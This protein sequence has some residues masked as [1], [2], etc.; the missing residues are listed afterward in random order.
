MKP[1]MRRLSI[2]AGIAVV[3]GSGAAWAASATEIRT[4]IKEV[5]RPARI[6]LQSTEKRGAVARPGTVLTLLA[7]SVPAKMLRVSRP[8]PT[9]PKI[10]APPRVRH[11]DSY[12]RVT[13][14]GDG[15]LTGAP[16]EL[17]LASGTR[18][19]LFD[20]RVEQGQVRFFTHTAEPVT[21]HD[22]GLAYGCTE[23]VFPVAAG[24]SV[25]EALGSINRVLTVQAG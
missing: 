14:A 25:G 18:L 1:L 9:H 3:L 8:E 23:F 19:V 21:G 2:V 4:A 5:Y 24:A 7:D 11:I 20:V 10:Q 17:T 13:V 22:G 15:T 6:E 12:A 16:G